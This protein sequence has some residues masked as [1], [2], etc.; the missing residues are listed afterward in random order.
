MVLS[1]EAKTLEYRTIAKPLGILDQRI[2]IAVR[3]FQ[4]DGQAIGHM[5]NP[6]AHSGII[7]H[8]DHGPVNIG[9]QDFRPAAPD[10]FCAEDFSF[11]DMVQGK[12]CPVAHLVLP[13]HRLGRDNND[14]AE[15]LLGKIPIFGR[16]PATDVGWRK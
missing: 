7:K 14:I 15:Q 4:I 3:A 6:A 9:N 11:R 13:A 2:V 8:V 16:G 1:Q 5:L 12:M 10:R